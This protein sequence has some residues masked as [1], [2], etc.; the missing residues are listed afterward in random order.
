MNT[1]PNDEKPGGYR[2]SQRIDFLGDEIYFKNNPCGNSH[3]VKIRPRPRWL[4]ELYAALPLAPDET[5][6]PI[7]ALHCDLPT[8]QELLKEIASAEKELEV[9]HA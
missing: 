6:S 5:I 4:R 8:K 2:A 1:L 3:Q 9:R 7:I